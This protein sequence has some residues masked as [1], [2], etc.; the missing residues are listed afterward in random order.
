MPRFVLND[1]NVI[2][3]YGFKIPT[4]GIYLGRFNANPVMLD[5]HWNSNDSVIGKWKDIEI[6]NGNLSAETVFNLKD[7]KAK[8][9]SEK[10]DDDFIKSA[11]MGV[12]FKREDLQMVNGELT[13]TKCELLEASIVA[14]PSNANALKLYVDGKALTEFDVQTL[15]LSVAQNAPDDIETPP[16]Q[17][18]QTENTMLKLS[19]LAF[20]AL[21]FAE[22]TKEASETEINK[23]VLALKKSKE[24]AET[25]LTAAELKLSA[26]EDKEK[27]EQLALSTKLV[28]DA[29]ASGRITADKKQ[30]FLD[31]AAQ[32]FDL[33][34]STIESIPAKKSLAAE[35]KTIPGVEGIT[36]M[37]DFQKLSLDEQI[38]F[39]AD[40][41]EAYQL[42]LKS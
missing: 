4:A 35:V 28:D 5:G 1:E 37:E 20:L 29:V 36:K 30:S 10:V 23:A 12:A 16:V 2:N 32:N 11:S 40:H 19:E 7:P 18:L 38:A 31:L 41:P 14:I 34:K 21:G 9:I 17:Q 25:K 22:F 3:S 26:L 6:S 13:L 24:D 15:C 27:T 33:A 39:K 42:I 8:S